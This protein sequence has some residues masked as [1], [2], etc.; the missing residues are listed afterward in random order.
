[1]WDP[2][3]IPIFHRRIRYDSYIIIKYAIKQS[4]TVTSLPGHAARCKLQPYWGSIRDTIY[5]PYLLAVTCKIIGLFA[6]SL[7][8]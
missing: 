5:V 3:G 4:R 8:R 1:M 6:F 7:L 2:L